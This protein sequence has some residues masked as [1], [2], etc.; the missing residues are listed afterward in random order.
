M[1]RRRRSRAANQRIMPSEQTGMPIRH[2]CCL[3]PRAFH[4]IQRGLNLADASQRRPVGMMR[5]Q[6][7]LGLPRVPAN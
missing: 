4:V 6:G 7:E 1:Y 3:A 5:L 2:I